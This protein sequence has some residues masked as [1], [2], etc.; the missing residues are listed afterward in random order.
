MITH[1]NKVLARFGYQ[2]VSSYEL[3]LLRS[4]VQYQRDR[5]IELLAK[6]NSR[7]AATYYWR[8]QCEAMRRERQ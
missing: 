5:N 7:T 8:K 2:L 6:I 1:I 4:D 3:D